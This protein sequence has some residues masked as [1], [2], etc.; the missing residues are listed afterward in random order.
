MESDRRYELAEAVRRA[1]LE[2]AMTAYEDAGISGL[3][4]DGR[5]ECAIQA[6]KTLDLST[7][8]TRFDHDATNS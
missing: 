2:A 5:W 6:M 4:E 3:C 1:C 7:V 8:I